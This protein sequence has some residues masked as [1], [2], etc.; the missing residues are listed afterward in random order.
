MSSINPFAKK[1]TP[2]LIEQLNAKADELEALA[3]AKTAEAS[4]LAKLAADAAAEAETAALHTSA[5]DRA[6]AILADAGV[7]L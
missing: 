2:T 6:T 4:Q 5:V 3:A 1:T 7:K